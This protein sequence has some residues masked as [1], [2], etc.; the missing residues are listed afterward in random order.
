MSPRTLMFARK[1]IRDSTRP[2]LLAAVLVPYFGLTAF[3]SVVLT[4]TLSADFGNAPVFTQEQVLI[5]AYSQLSFVW[6][7]MFPAVFLAVLAAT[8]V[9]GHLQKG[10]FRV[11]LSKPVSRWEPLLGKFLGIV[12]VSILTTLAG[13]L[14][15]A[16]TLLVASGA[17]PLAIRG[18][19]FALIPGALLFGVFVSVFVG[20]IGVLVAV[21]TAT[22]LQTAL[23]TA[24]IPVSFFA[25]IFVRLLPIG[26]IYE[27]FHLYAIDVNYHF[28]NIYTVTQ[29]VFGVEFTPSGREAFTSV[30]GVYDTASVWSDPLLGGIGGSTPL[31]GYLP[32]VLSL[33]AL[34]VLSIVALAGAV[35]RFERMDVP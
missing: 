6:L 32:P 4:Q 19:L 14:V 12:V 21:V 16:V 7:V 23:L 29:S 26:T 20:A 28:G 30:S 8:T 33:A 13:L 24:L 25:F 2:K 17:S 27:Q 35:Y 1:A 15:G 34:S 5:E 11:L 10:T 9:A 3:L 22:R 31:T 18:S